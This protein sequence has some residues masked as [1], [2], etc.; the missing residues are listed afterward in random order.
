MSRP[1]GTLALQG[2][3]EVRGLD[4]K[5]VGISIGRK[6]DY[7]IEK[8]YELVFE[9]ARYLNVDIRFSRVVEE[10]FRQQR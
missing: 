5:I 1:K 8:I 9:G 3:E 4:S 6:A 2:G 10:I 7:L